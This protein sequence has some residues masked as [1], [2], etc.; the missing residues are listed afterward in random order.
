IGGTSLQGIDV[1][2]QI[3]LKQAAEVLKNTAGQ[4]R[5]IFFVEQLV[6]TRHAQNDRDAFARAPRQIRGQPVIFEIIGDQHS[7]T[8]GAEDLRA[9]EEIAAVNLGAS[10][11]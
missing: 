7:R 5:V 11:Q 9:P 3:V 4:L 8:A 6:K 10:G 2:F 1:N